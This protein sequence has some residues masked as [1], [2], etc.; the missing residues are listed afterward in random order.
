MN[1]RSRICSTAVCITGI[2]DDTARIV[3]NPDIEDIKQCFKDDEE[4]PSM[5]VADPGG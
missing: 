5:E 4:P 1:P 2:V 3:Y